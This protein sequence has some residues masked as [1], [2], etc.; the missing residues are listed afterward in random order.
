M[1]GLYV[2]TA[3]RGP[4]LRGPF[5]LHYRDVAINPRTVPALVSSGSVQRTST[6]AS[7]TSIPPNWGSQIQVHVR[8]SDLGMRIRS[9]TLV[10][11]SFT[12]AP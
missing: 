1:A 5:S 12:Q 7:L 6:G 2:G 3:A 8:N 11:F 9:K 10:R 4:R